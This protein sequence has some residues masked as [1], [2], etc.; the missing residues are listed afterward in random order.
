[1]FPNLTNAI[2]Q[3]VETAKMDESQK[4]SN[5]HTYNTVVRHDTALRSL[6]QKITRKM[7]KSSV[8][9]VHN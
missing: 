3:N 2:K 9:C 1:M 5:T 7:Y 8:L 6:E 4:C